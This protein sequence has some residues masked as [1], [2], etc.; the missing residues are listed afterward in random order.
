MA[1]GSAA[2]KVAAMAITVALAVVVAMIWLGF[3]APIGIHPFF[4]F[5]LIFIGGGAFGLLLSGVLAVSAGSRI[6]TTPALDSR[7]FAGIRRGALAMA[8][9]AAVTNGLGV[10]LL[11]AIMG[12][13]GTGIPVGT[14]ASVTAFG[15]AAVTVVCAAFASV[16]LRR[17][18]PPW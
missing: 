5:V 1:V 14:G 15:A 17:A 9:L 8:L 18:L 12:G 3:A 4:Y 7:F 11:L 13:R 10:L 2:R 16:V 6:P